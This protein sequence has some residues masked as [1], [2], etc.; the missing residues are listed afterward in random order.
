MIQKASR[1]VSTG[2]SNLMTTYVP[3]WAFDA[4]GRALARV[5]QSSRA[6]VIE[7]DYC[8]STTTVFYDSANGG[9]CILNGDAPVK[10]TLLADGTLAT[11]CRQCD[12]AHDEC[13]GEY[14]I[15]MMRFLGFR[16]IRCSSECAR[17][18]CKSVVAD[19]LQNRHAVLNIEQPSLGWVEL[20]Y[21]PYD[22]P[23]V[24]SSVVA[25]CPFCADS[26]CSGEIHPPAARSDAEHADDDEEWRHIF[27][28]P[29][30]RF[31]K[32]EQKMTSGFSKP[33]SMA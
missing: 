17:L 2:H 11:P 20:T 24:G 10:M 5:H 31:W 21:T 3:K 26:D 18:I 32:A 9:A 7:C 6:P 29:K 16:I 13:D 15:H 1:S 30:R 28:L 14:Q 33:F 19:P 4:D 8:G 23:G 25:E 22:T 27:M 12:N